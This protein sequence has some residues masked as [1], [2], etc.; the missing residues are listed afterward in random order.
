MAHEK[1]DNLEKWDRIYT[2]VYCTPI[3]VSCFQCLYLL[4]NY[5]ANF[6]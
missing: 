6:I 3:W 2:V 4:W 1:D 5:N